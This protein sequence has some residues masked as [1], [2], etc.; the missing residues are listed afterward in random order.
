ML[1]INNDFFAALI[2][3]GQQLEEEATV[4]YIRDT[5]DTNI[6]LPGFEEPYTSVINA[7]AAFSVLLDLTDNERFHLFGYEVLSNS[8]TII[9]GKR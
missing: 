5:Y 7:R 3:H 6:P 8:L 4:Y 2:G 9:K 1:N